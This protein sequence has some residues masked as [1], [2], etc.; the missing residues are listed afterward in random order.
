MEPT[1]TNRDKLQ[2]EKEGL[3]LRLIHITDLHFTRGNAFQ[4]ALTASLL[5][6]AKTL[7]DSGFAPD[8][9]LFSG[10]LVNNPDEA[11][12]YK[13]CE[14]AV[15]RPLLD[16]FRLAPSQLILCPGNHDVSHRA[17]KE[18]ADERT[19]LAGAMAASQ[20]R[21]DQHLTLAPTVAYA[22][23][24]SEDFFDLSRRCGHIW[25]NPF[26]HCYNFPKQRVSFV[27]PIAVTAV[28]PK[29]LRLI[30]GN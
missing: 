25:I 1:R 28:E 3:T 11:G 18:W 13:E 8:F 15:I 16:V 23:A 5:V 9:V 30:A 6:D 27:S 17:L 19:K 21:L 26:A 10:D 7:Y 29:G 14:E 12:I 4:K 2:S 24:L 20:S 22:R